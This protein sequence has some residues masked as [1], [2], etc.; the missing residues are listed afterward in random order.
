MNEDPPPRADVARKEKGLSD[1]S[2]RQW[3]DVAVLAVALSSCAAVADA[4]P[5]QFGPSTFECPY[6]TPIYQQDNK[7]GGHVTRHVSAYD[8]KTVTQRSMK[9]GLLSTRMELQTPIICLA[10]RQAWTAWRRPDIQ[11]VV[12]FLYVQGVH[13]RGP[14]CTLGR[15]AAHLMDFMSR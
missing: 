8:S 15:V 1:L 10:R 7:A 4:D 9:A 12:V 3:I 14:I 11:R 13:R 5:A 6:G 2:L